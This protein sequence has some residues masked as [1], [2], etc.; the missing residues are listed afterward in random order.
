[1]ICFR[2]QPVSMF[3]RPSRLSSLITN[4]W[5]GGRGFRA[6]MSRRN[7]GRFTNSAPEIPSST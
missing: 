2:H 4:T 7:P 5:N 1:M 6:F 3:S